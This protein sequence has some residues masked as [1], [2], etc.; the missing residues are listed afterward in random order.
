MGLRL[1][2]RIPLVPG[3][4]LNLSKRGASLSIGHRGGWFTLGPRGTRATVGGLG[5][6]LYYTTKVP[7]ATAPH[8][9]HQA[10]FVVVLIVVVVLLIAALASS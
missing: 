3:L 2:K 10:G 9:G 7:P 4:R 6:G 5:S 1:W 8:A